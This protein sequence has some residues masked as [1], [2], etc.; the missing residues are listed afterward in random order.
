MVSFVSEKAVS[1]LHKAAMFLID[2]ERD[3]S[4]GGV[5]ATFGRGRQT[6][7]TCS[8]VPPPSEYRY[9]CSVICC[10]IGALP[11]LLLTTAGSHAGTPRLPLGH[12]TV[13]VLCLVLS[14][15]TN[16]GDLVVDGPSTTEPARLGR[17]FLKNERDCGKSWNHGCSGQSVV[18][19][20]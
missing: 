13:A 12:W 17:I 4:L 19:L 15:L 9:Y 5:P 3:I 8:V 16:V 14:L 2:V 6:R 1:V 7:S 10:R 11:L 18:R 20:R